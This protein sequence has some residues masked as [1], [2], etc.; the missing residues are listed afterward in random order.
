MIQ[1]PAIL[2]EAPLGEG[3]TLTN[4]NLG[5]GHWP[6]TALPGELGNAV[7]GAHR[8]SYTHPFRD[9]DRL[10]VGDQ[11]VM[12]V[13]AGK[14]T[15]TVTGSEVVLPTDLQVLDQTD[16]YSATLFACTPK[17]ETTH[18]IVIYLS[19]EQTPP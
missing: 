15:Y 16:S 1:I 13:N 2:V 18:R 3:V 11:V 14:F 7:I 17:G 9:V 19:M 5:P 10:T 6:G 8:V 4:L 12:T